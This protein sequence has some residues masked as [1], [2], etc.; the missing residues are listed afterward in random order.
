MAQI[1]QN[2]PKT[3]QPGVAPAGKKPAPQRQADEPADEP[4]QQGGEGEK[5]VRYD[6]WASI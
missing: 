6:D 2:N 3:P 5:P 4:R 1:S